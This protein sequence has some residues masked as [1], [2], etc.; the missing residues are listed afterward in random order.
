MATGPEN[1]HLMVDTCRG[2]TRLIKHNKNLR[3]HRPDV[4]CL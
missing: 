4:Y 3:W 2:V 1:E